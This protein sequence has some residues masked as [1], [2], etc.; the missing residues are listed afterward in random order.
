MNIVKIILILLLWIFFSESLSSAQEASPFLSGTQIDLKSF[1]AKGDGYYDDTVA[2]QSAIDSLSSKGGTILVSSLHKITA[3][4]KVS[5]NI[6]IIGITPGAGF[7]FSGNMVK[8]NTFSASIKSTI[9]LINLKL[10]GDKSG[11]VV[12]SNYGNAIRCVGCKNIIIRNCH[13]HSFP[14]AGIS[15]VQ[16]TF[17]SI[18]DNFIYDI[19]SPTDVPAVAGI[20]LE[21]DCSDIEI[22]GNVIEDIGNKVSDYGGIG[23]RCIIQ[24]IDH[25]SPKKVTLT[26]NVIKNVQEHGIVFYNSKNQEESDSFIANNTIVKTGNRRFNKDSPNERG[27]GIYALNVSSLNITDNEISETNINVSGNNILKGAIAI[28]NTTEN[29]GPVFISQNSI[30][31]ACKNGIQVQG[32]CA[33]LTITKNRITNPKERSIIIGGCENAQINENTIVQMNI[34]YPVVMLTATPTS[35]KNVVIINNNISNGSTSVY[36][37]RGKS[38]NISNNLVKDFNKHAIFSNDGSDIN[39]SKNSIELKKNRLAFYSKGKHINSFFKDNRI[40]IDEN[41]ENPYI[42][43]ESLGFCVIVKGS[44][45][46]NRGTWQAKDTVINTSPSG[47]TEWI[48][49]ESGIPG[50]WTPTF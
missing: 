9:I 47:V 23:I 45:A 3:T 7:L 21:G 42:Q 4:L 20:T 41:N 36:I 13:I 30:F 31:N 34:E 32:H 37:N 10:V 24:N 33:N 6:T 18:K 12:N 25:G 28:A 40:E 8:D 15:F 27:N 50:K 2:I 43:N 35:C 5:S 1:G 26:K 46:P 49:V 39:V 22:I 29:K 16:T 38:I 14:Q 19:A 44:T 48:C 17:S 11:S